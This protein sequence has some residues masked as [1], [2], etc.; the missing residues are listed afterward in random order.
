MAC[1]TG[2][3]GIPHRTY[4]RWVQYPRK[5]R[6]QALPPALPRHPHLAPRGFPGEK[7]KLPRPPVIH[8][9]QLAPIWRRTY[10]LWATKG[11]IRLM[12]RSPSNESHLTDPIGLE[13]VSPRAAALAAKEVCP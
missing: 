13:E 4:S 1:L 2:E 5:E 8:F 7:G 6:C 11:M 9:A 10:L 12:R 3:D